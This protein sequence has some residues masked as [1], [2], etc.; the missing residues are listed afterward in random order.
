[1]FRP[2]PYPQSSPEPRKLH[3]FEQQ[4][5]NL[6][7][8]H[9]LYR[10]PLT[11]SFDDCTN[12]AGV[13]M[14]PSAGSGNECTGLNDGS[15]NSVLT[16]YLADAWTWG[17]EIFCGVD[18]SHVRR[19]ERGEGYTVHFQL[20]DSSHANQAMWIRAVCEVLCADLN[21]MGTDARHRRNS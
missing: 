19:H 3:V 2:S 9:R 10:P 6:G 11:V 21:L 8:N 14:R 5:K 13:T 12:S 20:T 18:A 1:M 15:K 7:L 17:A 4:A 16:T